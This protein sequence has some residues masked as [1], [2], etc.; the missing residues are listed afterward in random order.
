MTTE[1]VRFLR[2]VSIPVSTVKKC[3][4]ECCCSWLEWQNE[5]FAE[6]ETVEYDDM[7]YDFGSL[8]YPIDYVTFEE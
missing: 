2:Q 5:V 6:G 4:E 3:G 8:E 1:Y 7:K